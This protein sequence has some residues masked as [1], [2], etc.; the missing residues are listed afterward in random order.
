MTW[1]AGP[2]VTHFRSSGNGL[3]SNGFNVA[4]ICGLSLMDD[5]MGVDERTPIPDADA[6]KASAP[7]I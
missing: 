2:A 5:N 6:A 4:P 1:P 3:T 7:P